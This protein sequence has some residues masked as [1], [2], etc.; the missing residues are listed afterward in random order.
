MCPSNILPFCYHLYL[1]KAEI[2]KKSF[3]GKWDIAFESVILWL[4]RSSLS[5][6]TWLIGADCILLTLT[7]SYQPATQNFALSV[8][9]YPGSQGPFKSWTD[10]PTRFSAMERNWMQ[11]TLW[12]HD[13]PHEMLFVPSH[14]TLE[15]CV[16]I[17]FLVQQSF[18]E[19]LLTH[20]HHYHSNYYCWIKCGLSPRNYCLCIIYACKCVRS[21]ARTLRYVSHLY[22]SD[23][24][25]LQTINSSAWET[26]KSTNNSA[27]SRDHGKWWHWTGSWK[28]SGRC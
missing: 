6:L 10:L 27:R 3:R 21:H 17:C 9:Q 16:F 23:F 18:I 13:P 19:C 2:K 25:K 11:T 28:L 20:N 26:E 8:L 15:Q 24:L 22:F 14:P 5:P 1:N 4:S 12:V 7:V